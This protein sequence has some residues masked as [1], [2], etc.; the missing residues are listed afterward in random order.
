MT[1]ESP[2][3]ELELK[4][5]VPSG[6]V[7]RLSAHRLLKGAAGASR[8]RLHGVY[9]DTPKLD[10]LRQGIALRLRRDGER[11]FQAAKGG[12]TALAG[13]HRRVEDEV[14][15]AGPALDLSR[16]VHAELARVLSSEQLRARLKPVFVTD[17][18]RSSRLLETDSGAHVEASIDR[19]L[20]KCGSRTE[21]VVELEL[22]LKSG[23]PRQLYEFALRL[24]RDL[25]LSVENRSKAERGYALL[26]GKGPK[27]VKAHPA[28][29]VPALSVGQ[30]FKAVM[31][32]GLTHLQANAH[33]LLAGGDLEYLHQMRVALRRLRSAFS[34]FEPVMP[35]T[36]APMLAEIKWLA[37][38]LGSAR[39]W[40]VFLTETLPPIKK[41]FGSHGE[42]KAF[43]ERCGELRRKAGAKARRAVRS[44]RYQRLM[45]SLAGWLESWSE[46]IELE[47]EQ[48][49]ALGEPIG[50]FAS[51]VLGQR[52]NRVRARGRKFDKLSSRELHRVR[53]AVKKFRYATDFF[54][55]LYEGGLARAALHRLSD[56]QDILGAINDAATV[57]ELMAH[58][59]DGAGGMDVAEAKGILLGWSRGRAETLKR[60][61]MSAWKEFRSAERFW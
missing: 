49:A 25:P 56:L 51:R 39:D 6:S 4:L 42:L 46:P 2:S 5:L 54:A 59:F 8:R 55:G 23:T 17:F 15:V 40:D 12:G 14:E 18:I 48:R 7:R 21:R 38:S 41:E 10:L 1:P 29:L 16:V 43:S 33:G 22:E 61:L 34:V 35:G 9:Y 37:S 44:A 28:T 3:I 30:A 11:W 50:A 45:L 47:P 27:P 32:A 20:I 36:A 57:T 26:R 60:E 31:Q 19:G 53:I 58:G 13:L 52:Y 24:V